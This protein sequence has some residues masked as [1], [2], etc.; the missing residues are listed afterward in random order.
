MHIY[1]TAETKT[2]RE[3]W[4]TVKG[5]V[6]Y[7]CSI[8]PGQLSYHK[9]QKWW[10]ILIRIYT[11]VTSL[12]NNFLTY[13]D[14]HVEL[15]WILCDVCCFQEHTTTGI[16]HHTFYGL[17]WPNICEMGT[18]GEIIGRRWSRSGEIHAALTSGNHSWRRNHPK[19]RRRIRILEGTRS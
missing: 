6:S 2:G 8:K 10:D 9:W 1:H 5:S 11:F 7:H 14:E 4:L 17:G 3:N 13:F 15:N 18:V 12:W 19:P 16:R